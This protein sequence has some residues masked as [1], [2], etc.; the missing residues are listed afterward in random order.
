MTSAMRVFRAQSG[1][2]NQRSVILAAYANSAI[3][4]KTGESTV[5]SR[6]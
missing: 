1:R 3:Q 5:V 4:N 2:P 6:Q